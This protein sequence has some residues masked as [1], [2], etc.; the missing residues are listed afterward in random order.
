MIHH[1]PAPRFRTV[2]VLSLGLIGWLGAD[3]SFG[4]ESGAVSFSRELAPI[5]QQKCVT[6]HGPEK[7]KGGFRLDT[8]EALRRGGDSK[9]PP[10]VP[11]HPEQSKLYQ[12][13]VTKDPDDRMPQKD[14]PLPASQIELI[15]RWIREG[16]AFDGPD[17]KAAYAASGAVTH[18]APPPSYSRPVPIRTL[19][20]DPTGQSLAV[21]GYHEVT[22]WKWNDGTLLRR[23]T[24][25][26]QQTLML[27][28]SPD[29]TVLAVASGKPGRS[30]E[31]RLIDPGKGSLLKRLLA[32]NDMVLGLAFSPDGQ[33]LAT[34]GA[35]NIIRIFNVASGQEE[36]RIEQHAD[37]V[38]ALAYSPDGTLLASAS[39]DKSAR[40]FAAQSGELDETYT[41]HAQ[42]IFGVAFSPDGKSVISG[43]RDKA[44]HIWQVK[45]AKKSFEIGGFDSAISRLLVQS[46]SLF[47]ASMDHQ[48]R[49]HRLQDKKA[50]LT[51]TYAGHQDVVYALAYHAP[52][53]RLASGSYDGEVRIWNTADGSL[54]NSFVAAPGYAPLR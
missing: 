30:G 20:F 37:W 43:G 19:A 26:D 18:P 34:G 32:V 7:A 15:Q 48:V 51:R 8:F 31:V 12:L 14:D 53:E 5:L 6:C 28:Y 40:L 49:Q 2:A 1:R 17:P 36:R 47:T 27:A 35:D 13:L 52:S 3:E 41:G 46:N 16:A 38:M 22:L 29:G 42:P 24:N 25:I 9:E 50:D 10:V 23:V 33:K 54:V 4:A 45:E 11:G 21:G 39:R 44:I